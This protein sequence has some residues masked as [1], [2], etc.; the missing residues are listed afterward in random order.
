MFFPNDFRGLEALSERVSRWLLRH[1]C[2]ANGGFRRHGK[3]RP[4]L[5]SGL[6]ECERLVSLGVP[7]SLS[8]THTAPGC[9]AHPRSARRN[10]RT[11]DPSRRA[12]LVAVTQ[13]QSNPRSSP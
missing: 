5:G 6:G 13:C 2:R 10:D 12:Q 11:T 7:R 1:W 4:A 8:V 3:Q 9:L